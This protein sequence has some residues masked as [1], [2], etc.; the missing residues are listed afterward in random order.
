M[1][2]I[3]IKTIFLIYYHIFEGCGNF[4]FFIQFRLISEG[5]FEYRFIILW[6]SEVSFHLTFANLQLHFFSTTKIFHTRMLTFD[7]IYTLYLTSPEKIASK[8]FQSNFKPLS[9]CLQEWLFQFYHL[10]FFSSLSPVSFYFFQEPSLVV[11]K[12]YK[13]RTSFFCS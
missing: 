1:E 10:V 4:F 9:N 6:F 8:K 3:H 13:P 11:F 2:K 12:R 7:S 5:C